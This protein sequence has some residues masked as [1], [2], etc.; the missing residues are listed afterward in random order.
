MYVDIVFILYIAAILI[1]LVCMVFIGLIFVRKNDRENKTYIDARRFIVCVMLT[2]L[3]YFVF[4]YREVVQGE[5]ALALPFRIADYILCSSLIICWLILLGDMLNRQRH[6]WMIRLGAAVTVLRIASSVAV[7]TAFMGVYY[8]IE[9][10]RIRIV[11]TMVESA[12]V[13]ITALLIIY[14]G[15][16]GV[17]ECSMKL[18][19]N[20]IAV[21][22]ALLLAWN[23]VQGIID[24]GLFSGKYGVSAWSVEVPDITGAMMFLMNLATCIFVFKEDFSPLFLSGEAGDDAPS[25]IGEKLDLIATDHSLTVREREVMELLYNGF[26]NHDI[27]EALYISVNTVKKHIRNIYEKLDVSSRIELL[28]LIN[29]WKGK[30][31]DNAHSTK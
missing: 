25:D 16:C 20:Y 15:I 3:L 18:R 7:T 13:L 4:Y 2:D 9:D 21:C 6:R 27:A 29:A 23:M 11:W 8:N 28:H 10:P 19:R 1:S 17:I 26:T 22:S 12:F 24:I 14:Y 31:S 5:Y 30:P